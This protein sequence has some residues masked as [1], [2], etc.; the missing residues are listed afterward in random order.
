M[1]VRKLIELTKVE[2][3]LAQGRNIYVNPDHIVMIGSVQGDL[4]SRAIVTL[5]IRWAY[6]PQQ[7]VVKQ[8]V[9]EVLEKIDAAD[10]GMSGKGRT[11]INT[12]QELE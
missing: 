9:R 2:M 7:I 4:D 12:D 6:S 3:F 5:S 1:I 11:R 8:S 10:P